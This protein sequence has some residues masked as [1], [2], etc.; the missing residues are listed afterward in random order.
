MRPI[1]IFT[2]IATASL[3]AC[4]SPEP[5][6]ELFFA[7]H[8]DEAKRVVEGCRDGSVRGEECHNAERALTRAKAK[9]RSERIFGDGKAY[10]PIK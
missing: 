8:L 2:A 9:E 5:R 10:T 7:E 4:G 3:S 1:W 6:S